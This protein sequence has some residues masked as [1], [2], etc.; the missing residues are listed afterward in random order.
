MLSLQC[1]KME[2]AIQDLVRQKI[3][4]VLVHCGISDS[5]DEPFKEEIVHISRSGKLSILALQ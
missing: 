4:E 1:I 5:S 2:E 3:R